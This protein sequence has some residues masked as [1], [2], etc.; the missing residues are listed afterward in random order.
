MLLSELLNRSNPVLTF[1][2]FESGHYDVELMILDDE[3]H[4]FLRDYDDYF[5]KSLTQESLDYIL[6]KVNKLYAL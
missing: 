1:G 3:L 4:V 5:V 2:E 6:N